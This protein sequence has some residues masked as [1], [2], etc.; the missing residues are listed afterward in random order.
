MTEPVCK[1]ARAEN[2]F[3]VEVYD[4][5]LAARNAKGGM[6]WNE[7]YKCYVFE[8]VDDVLKYLKDKL[9]NLPPMDEYDTAFKKASK[10]VDD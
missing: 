1:I 7:P 3:E 2:G 9:N 10:K 4:P 5:K 6:P 8:N